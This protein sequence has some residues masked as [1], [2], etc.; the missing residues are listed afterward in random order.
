MA[1]YHEFGDIYFASELNKSVLKWTQV[2]QLHWKPQLHE[3]IK[4]FN[5][6]VTFIWVLWIFLGDDNKYYSIVR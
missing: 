6:I 5:N 3:K 2:G 4:K 1:S